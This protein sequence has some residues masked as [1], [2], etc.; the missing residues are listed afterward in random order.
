MTDKQIIIDGVDVSGC[1]H[2]DADCFNCE[3]FA[4]VCHEVFPNCHYKQLKRKE[5]ECEILKEKLEQQKGYTVSYKSYVYEQKKQLNE[6]LDQLKAENEKLKEK[7]KKFFDIDNQECWDIAFLNNEKER[8]KQSLDEIEEKLIKFCDDC[9][10][11]EDNVCKDGCYYSLI[12]IFK[13]IINKAKEANN[14]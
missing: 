2:I 9:D 6:Q 5:Q 4:E 13:D 8:Y 12:P 1:K 7:F 11:R 10:G 14:D 3:I